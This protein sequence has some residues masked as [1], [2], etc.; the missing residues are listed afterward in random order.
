MITTKQK[1]ETYLIIYATELGKMDQFQGIFQ[2]ILNSV[3]FHPLATTA[4]IH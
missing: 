4:T 3:S 1:G 2:N